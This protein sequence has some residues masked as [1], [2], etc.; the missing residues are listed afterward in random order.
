[1]RNCTCVSYLFF[2]V[3]IENDKVFCRIGTVE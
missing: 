1:M 2:L 3:S